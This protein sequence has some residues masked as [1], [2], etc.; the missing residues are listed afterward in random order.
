[1]SFRG[2]HQKIVALSLPTHKS[3]T[4]S[5]RVHTTHNGHALR[6]GLNW[7]LQ[8]FKEFALLPRL[9]GA[10]SKLVSNLSDDLEERR[11][12]PRRLF[13]RLRLDL[14]RRGFV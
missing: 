2:F 4:V 12:W 5:G 10:A 1:M 11:L 6:G 3:F 7:R 8:V 13:L 9:G 14:V